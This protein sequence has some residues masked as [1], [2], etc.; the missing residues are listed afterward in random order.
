MEYAK[1]DPEDLLIKI[2]VHNRGP[3]TAQIHVLPT[4]WFRNVWSWG[5][6]EPKGMVRQSNDQW[7]AASHPNLGEFTLQCE[8]AEELLFTE[9]ESNASRLW[10]QPNPFAV[11]EGRVP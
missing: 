1:A 11:R 4:L 8:G 6:D 3:E 2:S 9:N 7:I 5:D 10:G